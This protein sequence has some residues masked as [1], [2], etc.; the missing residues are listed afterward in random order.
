MKCTEYV[1]LK[2]KLYRQNLTDV[3]WT[4][5]SQAHLGKRKTASGT[6]GK[7]LKEYPRL[8]THE[9]SILKETL[10]DIDNTR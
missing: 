4:E 3:S 6:W 7:T 9:M 10:I 1:D 5:I 2:W 8:E